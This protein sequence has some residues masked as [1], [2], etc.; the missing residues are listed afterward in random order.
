MATLS[1]DLSGFSAVLLISII[2]N[3]SIAANNS[4]CTVLELSY[5]NNSGITS[6]KL[7]VFHEYLDEGIGT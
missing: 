4:W 6:A 2:R 3:L 5:D 1:H 7:V